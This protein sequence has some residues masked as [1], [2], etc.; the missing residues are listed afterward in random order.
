MPNNPTKNSHITQSY[1]SHEVICDA[2]KFP[3]QKC[4]GTKTKLGAEKTPQSASLLCADCGKL[5]KWL[6]KADLAKLA[7][8]AK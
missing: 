7:G 5:L 6:T 3:C 1:H 8:G 2:Q 4:G